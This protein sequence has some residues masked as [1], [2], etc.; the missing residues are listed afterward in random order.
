MPGFSD[1]FTENMN[2]LGLP[3]PSSFF[4]S[5]ATASANIKALTDAV[6]KFGS[7]V[8]IGDLIGAGKLSDDWTL[9]AG[10][11]AAFY[12]GAVIGST[13]VAIN[14]LLDD[15]GV[16]IYDILRYMNA[17]DLTSSIPAW[18]PENH[19]AQYA[20][21]A[22]YA[23][24]GS[25]NGG[26][27]GTGGGGSGGITDPGGGGDAGGGSG[28]DAGGGGGGGGGGAGGGGGE[29]PSPVNE[30]RV[31]AKTS[32]A[33]TPA[34]QTN[35]GQLLQAMASFA[36]PSSATVTAPPPSA[37]ATPALGHAAHAAHSAH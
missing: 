25:N 6:E 34:L 31:V 11:T 28:G 7:D 8:T 3:T 1:Y 5:V 24:G 13:A 14:R 37:V 33:S 17:D 9:L 18:W 2:G 19:D 35:S 4:T 29:D 10:F 27:T 15:A 36:V 21:A 26:D 12:V 20:A 22:S 32:A 30:D 16:P 23:E